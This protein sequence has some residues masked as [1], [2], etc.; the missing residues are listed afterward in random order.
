MRY[1]CDICDWEYSLLGRLIAGLGYTRGVCIDKVY[2]CVVLTIKSLSFF[3]I[4]S[5][6][7]LYRVGCMCFVVVV[8]QF[9]RG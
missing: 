8:G 6:L 7:E 3:V 2:V 4:S 1:S 5:V 9:S